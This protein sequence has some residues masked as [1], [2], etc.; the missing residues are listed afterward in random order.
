MHEIKLPVEKN[1]KW[2]VVTVRKVSELQMHLG[3]IVTF[4]VNKVKAQIRSSLHKKVTFAYNPKKYLKDEN[5]RHKKET[6]SED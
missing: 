3:T 1:T 2:I 6:G 5:F 4:K